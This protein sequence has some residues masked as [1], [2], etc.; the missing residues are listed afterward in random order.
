MPRGWE[1]QADVVVVG[2]GFAGASAAIAASDA[3]ASVILLEKMPHPG[4][5]SIASGGSY[6]VASDVAG[7]SEYLGHLC[8]G[9]TPDDVIRA[10]AEGLVC[11]HSY[12]R[13]LAHRVG[14]ELD[15]STLARG[16]TYDLPGS[17]YIGDAKVKPIQ[18]FSGYPWARGLRGGARL[19]K[20]V[21]DNVALRPIDLRVGTAATRLVRAADGAVTGVVALRDGRAVRI[22]ARQAVVL[23]CGGFEFNETMKRHYWQGYPIY[24]VAGLGNTGDGIVMTQAL[25]A[26]Q[27]HLWHFHG[28]YG[29]KYPEFPFAIRHVN[30]TTREQHEPKW[31]WILVDRHGV[32]FTNEFNRYPQDL[33][34]RPLQHYD[35]Q[36][37]EYP[38]IPCYLI[39]DDAARR[40]SPM[41]M[42]ISTDQRHH[43][44]WS[45][46]NGE[47]VR[48]G[49]IASAAD[50]RAL[51]LRIGVD[52]D[53]LDATVERWNRFCARGR[54]EDFGRAPSSMLPI[55]QPPLYAMA[56]WP[57]VSNTQGGP[58]HDPDQRVMDAYGKPMKRLYA[59]GEL[60]SL[61]GHL[62]Q[63]AGNVSECLIGGCIAG[64]NAATERRRS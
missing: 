62:Y 30:I 5:I 19:F 49:W 58:V 39:F 20:V 31:L 35:S 53:N 3:G 9:S 50:P 32:R 45:A 6:L 25:G 27:W 43:Y 8:A 18:G 29:F 63:A 61:F 60:G 14:A 21:A 11:L 47:E 44:E 51:A 24:G 52:G 59:A 33:S 46:D 48:R 37:Q 23:A 64:E 41:G 13:G 15:E 4:G 36:R 54:D 10:Y 34:A 12:V 22:Q 17:E 28:A 1:D 42:P 40:L 57:I 2:Y 26:A 7:A 55:D 16:G 38:R 56:A